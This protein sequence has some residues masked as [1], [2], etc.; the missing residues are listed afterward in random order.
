[1]NRPAPKPH[2]PRASYPSHASAPKDL[3][4]HRPAHPS[5]FSPSIFSPHPSRF[6][7]DIA[8][9]HHTQLHLLV[10]TTFLRHEKDDRVEDRAASRELGKACP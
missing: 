4:P 1:V 8:P 9:S 10:R 7:L 3:I 2:T 5:A 6:F